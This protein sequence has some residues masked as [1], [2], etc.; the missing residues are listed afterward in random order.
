MV[1]YHFM[2]IRKK[3]ITVLMPE[4]IPEIF[5]IYCDGRHSVLE[6]GKDTMEKGC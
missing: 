5:F 2:E 4:T 3:V 6:K 1:G